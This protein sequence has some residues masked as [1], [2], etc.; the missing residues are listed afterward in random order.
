MAQQANCVN[1]ELNLV[2]FKI[3]NLQGITSYYN[4][5]TRGEIETETRILSK[6]EIRLDPIFHPL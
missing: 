3:L 1:K 4:F 5:T 2:R 6:L